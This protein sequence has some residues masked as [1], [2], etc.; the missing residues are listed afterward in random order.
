MNQH[1]TERVVMHRVSRWRLPARLA[2]GAL[3]ATMGLDGVAAGQPAVSAPPTAEAVARETLMDALAP[4]LAARG[5]TAL[6]TFA[7]ADARRVLAPCSRF[8]GFLPPG[9]RMASRTLVGVRCIEGASWQTFLS[10][11]VRVEAVTWQATHALRAGDP[12]GAGDVLP[13][14]AILTVSDVEAAMTAARAQAASAASSQSMASL[15]GRSPAPL[16][17]IVLRPVASGRALT[18]SDLRDEGRI[19]PGE[20]VR[21]VFRGDGFAVSSDGR[22]VGAAD[23]GGAIAIRLASGALVNGTLRAD[24]LVELNR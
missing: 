15:D 12:L 22:S 17:R 24:H 16:G 7:P 11:D 3:L 21:V 8:T 18:V 10:A 23:P 4:V 6:V 20:P 5:A 2:I 19:G 13:A 14:T 1:Q 9:A